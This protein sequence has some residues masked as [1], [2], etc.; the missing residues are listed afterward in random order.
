M[1]AFRRAAPI[2]LLT[3]TL[4]ACGGGGGS[5]DSAADSTTTAPS[6]DRTITVDMVDHAFKAEAL[7][8]RKGET[9]AF[10]FTNNGSVEH[11]AF[12][13]NAGE[14]LA[15]S[16]EVVRLKEAHDAEGAHADGSGAHPHP[17]GAVHL[18]PGKT[19]DLA[20]TFDEAEEVE[21]ACYEPGHLEAGMRVVVAVA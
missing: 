6:A 8:V 14:Q 18:A 11:E 10:R 9:V 12:V 17:E 16:R 5:G 4:A 3:L 15:Y 7:Q 1:P 21:I 19:G 20:Y 2:A 13:G